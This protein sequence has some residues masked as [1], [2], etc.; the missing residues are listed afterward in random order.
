MS[1]RKEIKYRAVQK[2]AAKKPTPAQTLAPISSNPGSA[3]AESSTP[4]VE[5]ESSEPL[6]PIFPTEPIDPIELNWRVVRVAR[7]EI[8]RNRKQTIA[9]FSAA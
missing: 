2:P 8:K 7:V 5:S 6:S 9:I 3:A 1:G 4:S